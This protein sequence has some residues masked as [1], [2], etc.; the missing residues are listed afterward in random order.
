MIP[1]SLQ[2]EVLERIHDGH[3]GMTRRY[4]RA[5]RELKHARFLD[6]GGNRKRAFRV[7]GQWCLPD[8]YTN[9]L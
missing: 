1:S 4:E 7:P 2:S 9:H 6:A 3:Q 5:N 8:F